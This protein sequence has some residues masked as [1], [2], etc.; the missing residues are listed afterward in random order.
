MENGFS[1]YRRILAGSCV[2][3]LLS[4]GGVQ[5]APLTGHSAVRTPVRAPFVAGEVIVKLKDGVRASSVN[6]N[7]LIQKSLGSIAILSVKPFRTDASFAK[8]KIAQSGMTALAISRISQ[9]PSI[10]YAEP[11]FIYRTSEAGIPSDTDFE[12]LWGI[13][14][15][16]QMDAAGQ[17]GKPGADINVVPLWQRGITGSR[18]VV[19]AVI[20]TGVQWDHPDLEANVYT[21]P[22]EA[23]GLA[24]NGKDDDGN[25]FI[26][27]V[28]GW[29]FAA[30]T[31]AS[32]DDHDHGSHCSGTIGGVGDN[33][34]GVAGINWQVSILPVK[35]LD[36]QGGGTLEGAVESIKYATKMKVNIMSNSWGGGGYSEALKDAIVEAKNAGILFV[37]AAG[38]DGSDNDA[39]PTYPASYDVE[40]VVA[41]A[42]TDN[43]DKLAEFSN[44][45]KNRVHVAAPGV[46]VYSTIKGGAYDTFSGTS[47]ACPHVAGVSALLLSANP[48]WSFSEIKERLIKTSVPVAGL[49][50]K[51]MAKGRV[52]A[53][54]A[55]FNIVPPS[56]EPDPALW[57]DV[58]HVVDSAHPYAD[59]S[60]VTFQ[61]HHEG[62]K[63]IRVYFEKL[64]TEQSYDRVTVES[65]AGEVADDLTGKLTDYMS[66]YVKG[67][68]AVLRLTSDDSINEYGFR[69]TK[70]QVIK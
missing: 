2:V 13:K 45:G 48:G 58:P 59:K 63:Y 64:S 5:A 7:A 32:S 20:D 10:Q 4:M 39:T 26:D 53:N 43:M 37:A 69:V 54:N 19:V 34:K 36:G 41:V 1:N 23:G 17:V 6:M 24:A 51:V 44:Y 61:I 31:N 3:S 29:N 40:N 62:A 60:N 52:D 11:N 30:Q 57:M 47:M 67:D 25:G 18:D 35:F 15:V 33:G 14:N 50:R 22:G 66:E 9:D 49:R 55:F 8:V 70:I 56:D 42:A 21:N 46:K 68:T 12:K 38:N 65:G 27:D 16:G 28:H